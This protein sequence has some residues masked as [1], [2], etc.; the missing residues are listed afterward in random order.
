MD[1]QKLSHIESQLKKTLS[2]SKLKKIGSDSGFVIRNNKILAAPFICSLLNSLGTR[3]VQTL[4]DLHR[5]FNFDQ[6]TFVHYHPYYN[7][8]DTPCFPRMMKSLLESMMSEMYV[9]VL[10]P[11]KTGPFS[12][13]DDIQAHDGTSFALHSELKDVFPGRFTTIKPAAVELHVTMSLLHNCVERIVLTPDTAG[14]RQ[15][16]PTGD[17]FRNKLI[18]VDRGYLDYKFFMDIDNGDGGFIARTASYAKPPILKVF[19]NG[20][21]VRQLEG[22]Y[23][24]ATIAKLKKRAVY[25]FDVLIRRNGAERVFRMVLRYN[26]KDKTWTQLLTNLNR[27]EFTTE[28]ILAAYRLRWQIELLFKDWKS[29]ANLHVFST[30]KENIAE[31]LIWASL[32]VAFLKRYF[33]NA[34]QFT[35]VSQH[36]STR[37]VAM[38]SH[39]FL[40][41]LFRSILRRFYNL[42]KLLRK[43][44]NFFSFNAKRDNLERDQLSGRSVLL[45][46]KPERA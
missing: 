29:Y 1:N 5:D 25:E 18:L 23:I 8:L 46:V 30:R 11:L 45:T 44:F 12:R 22:K 20:K 24:D 40:P 4:C 32:C 21:R 34:C 16:R 2:A 38:L 26:T 41:E 19:K 39:N 42:D 17:V 43:T 13:F 6:D 28:N 9:K 31:G 3:R 33:A 37:I 14:E 36:F 27:R 7:K 15:H 35:V 10:A